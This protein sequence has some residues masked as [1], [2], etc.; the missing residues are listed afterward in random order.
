MNKKEVQKLI[1]YVNIKGFLNSDFKGYSRMYR[2]TTENISGFLNKYD[3]KDKKVLTVAGSGDQ[4]LNCYSLGAKDVTCFDVNPLCELHLKLKDSALENLSYK[5]FIKFMGIIMDDNTNHF[6]NSDL[7]D[8]FKNSL[9]D[10]AYDFYDYL[11]HGFRRDPSRNIYYDF[12]YDIR[13]VRDLNNYLTKDN[14]Y[15]LAGTIGNKSINFINVNVANL[16]EV[17]DGEKFD[18][19]LLS[20][21]SDYIHYIYKEDSLEQYRELIDKLI[22]NLYL[23]GTIQVGYI[24]SRYGKGEDVSKFH[25]NESRNKVFP[26]YIFHSNFVNSFYHDGTYDKIITYQKIK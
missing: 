2:M 5:E 12:D 17:L 16:S 22:D 21:I 11:I 24:Y 9:E 25:L 6:L 10:D 14:Y 13:K 23:Y 1:E 4:R 19:I 20:N 15:K 26:N 3:L 18:M 8:K 7:F